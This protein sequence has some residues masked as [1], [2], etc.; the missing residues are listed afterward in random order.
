MRIRTFLTLG[1]AI[2]SLFSLGCSSSNDGTDAN[3]PLPSASGGLSGSQ[4]TAV[5]G[6][7][8]A[9]TATGGATGSATTSVGGS[10]GLDG[11]GGSSTG[12][13]T[14]ATS[15]GGSSSTATTAGGSSVG[16]S[17]TGGTMTGGSANGGTATGGKSSS[18]TPAGGSDNGGSSSGGTAAGGATDGG[19]ATGG[20]ATGGVVGTGG[21]VAVNCTDASTFSKALTA[22][23]DGAFIPV[24]GS[25]KTYRATTNWWYRFTDQKVN[26]DQIGFTVANPSNVSVSQTDG[27]PTGYPAIYIG[28]YSENNTTGSNLPKQVSALTSVPTIFSTNATSLDTA[29]LNAAYD[30]WFTASNAL[31]G[32]GQSSPGRGGA[33]L[34]VWLFDPENRQ[35]RGTNDVPAHTVSGVPGTWDVW[36]DKTDPLCI[37]YVSTTPMDSLSFDLN[38]FIQ[39]SVTNSYGIT[40]SMYLSVIFAGFEI[41]G[42]GDGLDLKQFCADVK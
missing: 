28:A 15:T 10:T 37:S 18:S 32:R 9:Q 17:A 40:N 19:A 35:P 39:D 1:A 20:A 41:W 21:S 30:V 8:T 13:G 23:Y 27:N 2:P 5:T 7:N 42:G 25:T 6:G 22:R 38:N 14:S 29:N 33:Y 26:V 16:G 34:M 31:L 3:N 11:S 24:T 4:A 12:G 36:I